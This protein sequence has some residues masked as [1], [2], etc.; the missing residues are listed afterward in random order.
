MSE[1]VSDGLFQRMNTAP[2]RAILRYRWVSP[3]GRALVVRDR[4]GEYYLLSRV[5]VPG[6]PGGDLPLADDVPSPRLG[7]GYADAFEVDLTERLHTRAVGLPTV[8]GTE[9]MDLYV[10][11]WVH[12]PVRVVQSHTVH[13]WHVVSVE[14]TRALTILDQT[15]RGAQ[16]ELGPQDILRHLGDPK[17]LDAVG[18]TYRV[19]DVRRRE[20]PDELI[21][22]R[23]SDAPMPDSWTVNR[24]GEYEFCLQALRNGPASLAALWL[25]RC[26][27]QVSQVVDWAV[28]HQ[29]LLAPH[30]DWQEEMAALLGML[31]EQ[32]REELSHL[33]YERVTALGHRMPNPG[34]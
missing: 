25:L 6:E 31:S 1:V 20:S 2:W 8:Y 11:W 15:R 14:L 9:S 16:R 24:R 17:R 33:L 19:F 12:D 30:T 4:A 5:G 26:P 7:G 27:D 34:S 3:R 22:G 23:L 21:L 32:E 29:D 28:A 13:G 18:L 10:S